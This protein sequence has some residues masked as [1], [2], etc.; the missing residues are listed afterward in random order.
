MLAWLHDEVGLGNVD[1]LEAVWVKITRS[2]LK[3]NSAFFSA[4]FASTHLNYRNIH[5][6]IN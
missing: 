6:L 5:A 1:Q 4:S 2:R 3:W